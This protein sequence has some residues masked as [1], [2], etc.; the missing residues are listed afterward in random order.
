MFQTTNQSFP[1]QTSPPW[2]PWCHQSSRVRSVLR[3]CLWSLV[4]GSTGQPHV[5]RGNCRVP[6]SKGVKMEKTWRN[7]GDTGC[8]ITRWKCA[9]GATRVFLFYLRCVSQCRVGNG[10]RALDHN[11]LRMERMGA[12]MYMEMHLAASWI[13]TP[14]YLL[15][16]LM[17]FKWP[18]QRQRI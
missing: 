15:F 8:S 11:G 9:K 4:S 12:C 3:C 16:S 10:S 17:F 13:S 5:T 1:S 18:V 14:G 2:Q 7:V 6:C